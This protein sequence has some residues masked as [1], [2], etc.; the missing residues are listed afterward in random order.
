MPSQAMARG[1]PSSNGFLLVALITLVLV[2]PSAAVR[3]R[4][5]DRARDRT[6]VTAQASAREWPFLSDEQ[7][8]VALTLQSAG[9]PGIEM[10]LWACQKPVLMPPEAAAS[11]RQ[12][13]AIRE[14]EAQSKGD[15]YEDDIFYDAGD[16]PDDVDFPEKG[17]I[18]GPPG[19][20][21]KV[22]ELD[23][24]YDAEEFH[25]EAGEFPADEE[26]GVNG[27]ERF[28]A[29]SLADLGD[30]G[31]MHGRPRTLKDE[32]YDASQAQCPARSVAE[33]ISLVL[34]LG[35]LVMQGSMDPNE[36]TEAVGTCDIGPC[37]HEELDYLLS[38]G[39]FM[40]ADEDCAVSD[41]KSESCLPEEQMERSVARMQIGARRKVLHQE[42]LPQHVIPQPRICPHGLLVRIEKLIE[43]AKEERIPTMVGMIRAAAQRYCDKREK[44]HHVPTVAG[45][46]QGSA[47]GQ[48]GYCCTPVHSQ[49][50]KVELVA[51][52]SKHEQA[53]ILASSKMVEG[54]L[55]TNEKVFQEIQLVMGS[56]GHVK[57]K[58]KVMLYKLYSI[59]Y[60]QSRMLLHRHQYCVTHPYDLDSCGDP[61]TFAD[62]MRP[63]YVTLKG[64]AVSLSSLVS[65]IRWGTRALSE[66]LEMYANHSAAYKLLHIV[67]NVLLRTVHFVGTGQLTDGIGRIAFDAARTV[68][69]YRFEVMVFGIVVAG[70]EPLMEAFSATG[71]TTGVGS[72]W[73]L[74]FE[75]LIRNLVLYVGCPIIESTYLMG[76]LIRWSMAKILLTDTFI[77]NII[78]PLWAVIKATYV[79]LNPGALAGAIYDIGKASV[80]AVVRF[81]KKVSNKFK[82]SEA[83][84]AKNNET[85][86]NNTMYFRK[87]WLETAREF[88][89]TVAADILYGVL[90]VWLGGLWR[91]FA[92]AACET[93]KKGLLVVHGVESTVDILSKQSTT[94]WTGLVKGASNWL[95]GGDAGGS[96]ETVQKMA[97]DEAE[98]SEG[99][100]LLAPKVLQVGHSIV[101]KFALMAGTTADRALDSM[102]SALALITKHTGI[103][104]MLAHVFSWFFTRWFDLNPSSTF[105]RD[106]TLNMVMSSTHQNFN[107]KSCVGQRRFA[108]CMYL[109]KEG[110]DDAEVSGGMCCEGAC[111]RESDV[112]TAQVNTAR[113]GS[114]VVD[115]EDLFW[116]GRTPLHYMK[117]QAETLHGFVLM[118]RES[119][120]K[121]CAAPETS[122]LEHLPVMVVQVTRR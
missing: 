92:T 119:Y 115:E 75:Q 56:L 21:R 94:W 116:D 16:F 121:H 34:G 25:E 105:I 20:Q 5:R 113:N 15:D 74:V 108:K 6:A 28:N 99:M 47:P 29:S 72:S 114:A 71:I 43:L 69:N 40:K 18:N 11:D 10:L 54:I 4:D 117:S 19:L 50:R 24:W 57:Q 61:K 120:G 9:V 49:E 53:A 100:K 14:E 109:S 27:S 31:G 81:L 68:W 64:N 35:E 101:A 41:G 96:F 63:A 84:A 70:S 12:I 45:F 67:K 88:H 122:L 111:Q 37:K 103:T 36:F 44:R 106:D 80:G 55:T 73:G 38:M 77:N 90:T 86:A 110:D 42:G 66:E 32:L 82:S 102:S 83:N 17:T 76:M 8:L 7:N 91:S 48:T 59:H 118:A 89:M 51:E 78:Q 1:R 79:V 58:Q 93:V 112:C 2:A 3:V 26:D 107:S 22:S 85:W 104:L 33:R 52:K 65:C 23:A 62:D 13:R 97:K 95:K 30:T 98:A 87:T 46:L 39:I 60:Y